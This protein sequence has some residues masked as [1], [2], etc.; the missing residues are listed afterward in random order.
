MSLRHLLT[1]SP[2]ARVGTLLSLL[3]AAAF[4]IALSNTETVVAKQFTAALEQAPGAAVAAS[5]GH[6]VSGSEAY[7][8]AAKQRPD[9]A[10]DAAYEPAAWAPLPGG[11]NAGDRITISSG[12]SE[13]VLEVVAVSPVDTAVGTASAPGHVAVTCR[14]L[15]TPNHQLVT[16]LMPEGATLAA[17]KAGRTL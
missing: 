14:D 5:G 15:S 9:A 3:A 12:K 13:R 1:L 8:L 4:G 16:F 10:A 2:A 17:R 11:L 7:W 6:L